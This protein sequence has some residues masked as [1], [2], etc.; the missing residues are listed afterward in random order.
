[1][2]AICQRLGRFEWEIQH[3]AINIGQCRTAGRPRNAS[4]LNLQEEQFVHSD[5]E[6]EA[7]QNTIAVKKK[8]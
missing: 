8:I 4:A 3:K 1:M 5:T 2:I 6:D 7:D